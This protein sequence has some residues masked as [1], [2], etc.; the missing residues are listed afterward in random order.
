MSDITTEVPV[1]EAEFAAASPSRIIE[2]ALEDLEAVE[3][4]PERYDVRMTEWHSGARSD[5]KCAVCFAG[6]VIANRFGAQPT[7]DLGPIDFSYS[8]AVRLEALN[9][10]RGGNIASGLM[11]MDLCHPSGLAGYVDIEPYCLET[12]QFKSDM[13][14]LAEMLRANG[15]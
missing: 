8:T 9:E 4:M 11:E 1:R 12:T 13:R 14:A 10:F 15:L 3:R 7:E 5:L 6:S 2:M